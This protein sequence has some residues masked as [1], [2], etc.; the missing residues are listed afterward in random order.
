MKHIYPILFLH[1][2]KT[3]GITL[4]DVLER[5]YAELRQ[6][7]IFSVDHSNKF[8][9]SWPIF[10]NRYQVIR[11][12]FLYGLHE[13]L[14][15]DFHYITMIRNPVERTISGYN[16]I[17]IKTDHPFYHEMRKHNYSLYEFLDGKYLRN[18]DNIC[19]RF[20]SGD[21]KIPFGEI[22][23]VHFEKAKSNLMNSNLLFGITEK[24]EASLLHFKKELHWKKPYFIKQNAWPKEDLTIDEK[25]LSKIKECNFYD[26][27][28]YEFADG[29]FEERIKSYGAGFENELSAFIKE[30]ENYMAQ[31]SS[32]KLMEHVAKKINPN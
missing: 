22:N 3:A 21:N 15:G 26:L 7:V 25:T 4:H 29:V 2:P 13:S 10:R 20:L 24:F 12:H 31:K 23:H 1:I 16:F 32:S 8:K 27:K 14:K 28:L 18:F 6:K 17:K 30:N 9:R 19:V 5:E 11:G